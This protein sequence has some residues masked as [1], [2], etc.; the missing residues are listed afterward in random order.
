MTV[1]LAISD[2][3]PLVAQESLYLHREVSSAVTDTQ[4]G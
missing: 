4:K 1:L 2:S 3:M